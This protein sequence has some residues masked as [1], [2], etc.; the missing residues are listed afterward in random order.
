MRETAGKQ[1]QY[2]AGERRVKTRDRILQA[3]RE[4]FNEQGEAHVTLAH[5]GEHLGISEG[6]V[7]YHFRTK[8]DLI[9]AL[10]A[11]VQ[12]RVKA[13][14]QRDL[15]HLRQLSDVRDMFVEE[16][17]LMWEYRFLF[18]DHVDLIVTLP[19]LHEQLVEITMQGH[20]Y[21]KR[22]LARLCLIGL[23][24][25]KNSEM[26]PL[27]TNIWIIN[28]YWIDYCQTRSKQRQVTEQD[29]Q[30]GMQQI[31]TLLLPYFTSGL[32]GRTLMNGEAG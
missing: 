16:F 7:W 15:S 19:E 28:R 13:Q 23:L 9:L 22:V 25:I 3:A 1:A 4:L 14:Q 11:E 27:A 2:G 12:Q 21:I 29:F 30:E 32:G 5:I 31:R 18:Q 20:A 6:N 17:H 26:D 8:H 10:F 24:Q